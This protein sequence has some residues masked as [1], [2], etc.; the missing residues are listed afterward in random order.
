MVSVRVRAAL[1]PEGIRE[2]VVVEHVD[3]RITAV[4]DAREGDPEPLDGLLTAGLV[5]AHT[6]LELSALGLIPG[7]SF[8]TW[9]DGLVQRR[10]EVAEQREEAGRAAARRAFELGH[11]VL[12]DISNGG[13]TAEWLLD[14]GVSGVVQHEMLGLDRHTLPDQLARV[15][16]IGRVDRRG[17]AVVHTRPTPHA[18]TSTAPAL[19]A[20]CARAPDHAVAPSIHL[21]ETEGEMQF[22]ALGTG[23][24][25]RVLDQLQR[26]WRWWEPPGVTPVAYLAMLQVLDGRLMAVHCVHTTPEDR[27]T[28]AATRTPVCL[29]PRSNAHIEGSLPAAEAFVDQGLRLALGTDSLASS[30]DLD[31]LGEA[32]LL[33]ERFPGVSA[34]TWL[35][36]ATAGGADALGLATFGQ[37]ALGTAPGL[38]FFEGAGDA[39]A[40]LTASRR[41]LA[42]PKAA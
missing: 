22:L 38:L 34:E 42:P 27:A 8:L 10:H 30:P 35:R 21:A 3:G 20:L 23:P 37:L 12:C 19:I 36:A 2:D 13:D 32:R 24:A 26:D 1:L 14:A 25:A 18:P 5:N 40:A 15:L 29:C 6:H 33:R 39:E 31:V 9:L 41:W 11:A 16:E 7:G 4:R 17:G 28:L